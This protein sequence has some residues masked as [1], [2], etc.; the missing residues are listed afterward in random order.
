MGFPTPPHSLPI[1][2][3]A[4]I[5]YF[6]LLTNAFDGDGNVDWDAVDK[7]GSSLS[8]IESRPHSDLTNILAADELSTDV[9]RDKHTSSNDLKTAVD[10]YAKDVDPTGTNLT[11][12][13]H[14]ADND[15][16]G[17]IKSTGV[18][19]DNAVVRWDGVDGS[20][21]QT[22]SVIVDDSDNVSG[23][24]N[25]TASGIII[26]NTLDAVD[27]ATTRQNLGVEIG[28]DVQAWDT[29][30]DALAALSTV[31]MMVRIASSTYAMRTITAA[32]SR[33]V[34]TNGDGVGGNPTIALG[35]KVVATKTL[36]YTLTASDDVILADA[37]S[38]AFTLIMPVAVTGVI[39]IIKLIDA[40]N[41]L[42]IDGNGI[43]TIDGSS[44]AVISV[45]NTSLTF[46]GLLG[47]G[48]Y[49]I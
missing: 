29:D 13:K 10:H 9:E 4:W 43:E 42:T 6:N 33:I 44:N 27:S 15:L 3:P 47:T 45:L 37:S 30:L 20:A 34:V 40:T 22:S 38:G 49:I 48:W 2:H 8:D 46:V 39:K 7:S 1:T 17:L 41:V 23:I 36:N 11:R 26:A 24:E 35:V 19:A 5:Q 25:L 31:G 21:I 16:R 18:S 32:D 14:V 28:V 12:D